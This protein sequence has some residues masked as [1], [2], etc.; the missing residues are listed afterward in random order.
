L[1]QKRW[2]KAS[3]K[4]VEGK[5][6]VQPMKIE[7]HHGHKKNR[8][9]KNLISQNCKMD[10]KSFRLDIGKLIIAIDN[11]INDKALNKLGRRSKDSV[12]VPSTKMLYVLALQDCSVAKAHV[13]NLGTEDISLCTRRN[14]ADDGEGIIV[15]PDFFC[16]ICF[17]CKQEFQVGEH[18]HT[19]HIVH[20]HLF[21]QNTILYELPYAQFS[22]RPCSIAMYLKAANIPLLPAV[23]PLIV[24]YASEFEITGSSARWVMFNTV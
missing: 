18:Q 3:S 13:D 22:C 11:K 5:L 14:G 12:C 7:E 6:K 10:E 21:H 23:V 17:T 9:N 2:K 8:L 20:W 4:S 1:I 15:V 16:S 19:K 24:F